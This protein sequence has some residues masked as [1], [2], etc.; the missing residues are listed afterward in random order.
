MTSPWFARY[1]QG[2]ILKK[3]EQAYVVF[4]PQKKLSKSI[5]I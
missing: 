1:E 4:Y 2:L 3:G 5:K